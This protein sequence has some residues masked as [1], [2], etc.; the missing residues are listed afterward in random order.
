M[1][2]GKDK[3]PRSRRCET[4]AEKSAKAQKKAA[5]LGDGRIDHIFGRAAPEAAAGDAVCRVGADDEQ[6]DDDAEAT[7]DQQSAGAEN[8]T[9]AAGPS[10]PQYDT[11][12]QHPTAGVSR[13]QAAGEP[14]KAA[15]G[16]QLPGVGTGPRT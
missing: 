10:G 7:A 3:A 2:R 6:R 15:L 12:G 14:T 11:S 16:R 9:F 13:A 4:K 5:S 8:A 1:G